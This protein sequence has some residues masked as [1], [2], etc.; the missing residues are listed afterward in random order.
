MDNQFSKKKG[1]TLV[2]LLIVIAIV[3]M[4]SVLA[5]A[6]YSEYR[7]TTLLDLGADAIVAQINEMQANTIHG[8]V[9]SERFD[10]ISAELDGED[11]IAGIPGPDG[12]ALCYG[13]YFEDEKLKTFTV[14]F[15]GKKVWDTTGWKYTGCKDFATKSNVTEIE[16][17]DLIEV[18]SVQTQMEGFLDLTDF[19]YL[20][21]LPPEGEPEVSI[22]GPDDPVANIE[23]IVIEIRYGSSDD[24][25][26]QRTIE[27][28]IK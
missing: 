10:A 2:E 21:F 4:L 13:I 24:P 16:L 27:Y 23:K 28:E 12:T 1:F 22:S 25:K 19:G 5:I 15:D 18:E 17:D 8:N 26:Y 3:G 6:G 7:K 9:G 14:G 11:P 20:H